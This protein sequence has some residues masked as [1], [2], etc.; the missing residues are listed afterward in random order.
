MLAPT[1]AGT[2]DPAAGFWLGCRLVCGSWLQNRLIA[3]TAS[4]RPALKTH[5]QNKKAD[6]QLAGL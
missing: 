2:Y 6:G 5:Q 1:E 4:A 3:E